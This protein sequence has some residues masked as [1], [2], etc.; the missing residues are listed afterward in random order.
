MKEED[1]IAENSDDAFN[2]T[3]TKTMD[4]NAKSELDAAKNTVVRSGRSSARTNVKSANS[5]KDQFVL[6]KINLEGKE[7]SDDRAKEPAK[8]NKKVLALK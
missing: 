4:S 3:L 8:S 2:N 7:E 6:L 1:I 5:Q